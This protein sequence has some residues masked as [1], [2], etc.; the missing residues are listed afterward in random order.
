[1]AIAATGS[2]S[3]SAG[4]RFAPYFDGVIRGLLPL[5]ELASPELIRVRAKCVP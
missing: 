1:M 3:I 2:L 5:L 4:E